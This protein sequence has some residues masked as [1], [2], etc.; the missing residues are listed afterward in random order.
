MDIP[1]YFYA[2]FRDMDRLAPGSDKST[3]KA[4]S[5]ID[6]NKDS[7]LNILDIG[8]GAGASTLIL[9]DYFKNSTIEAID[10]F[11]HYLNVLDKKIDTNRFQTCQM[12]M[13]DLDYPNDE[14]D[15]VFSEAS[16]YIMGFNKAL[17]QWKRVIKDNGYL[18][19]S[20]PSWIKKPS[21]KSKN[22]WKTHYAELDTIE[23]KIAQINEN[24]EFI[25]YFILPKSDFKS[26]YLNLENNLKDL[27]NNDFKKDLKKE[28]EVYK[29]NNDDYSY[30]FYIMRKA[31]H[32]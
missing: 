5:Y 13:N 20:E 19:I 28:I 2:A 3:L 8:C 12:D 23:N 22:F 30:V 18:I 1:L 6:F 24:Y 15:I 14:F 25:D 29:S 31:N 21:K 10:L 11:N 32:Q 7:K 9:A 27:E 16:A 26:Y 17:I 4:I